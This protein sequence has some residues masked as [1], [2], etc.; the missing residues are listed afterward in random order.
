M[1]IGL[2]GTQSVGKSTLINE[3]TKLPEFKDYYTATE[4]SKHLRDLGIP[5]NTDST[6]LGQFVFIAERARELLNENLLT[7]RSIY[8][9]LAYTLSSKSISMI[10]TEEIVRAAR[11]MIRYYDIIFYVDPTG[12]SIEDNGVRTIDAE[13]R[14]KIDMV[15]KELLDEYP[16]NKLVN[17][18]P[19]LS[20][21]ER[22][23]FIRDIIRD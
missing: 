4:R 21:E 2:T 15:I 9:V 17:I 16:P 22:V 1:K 23:N 11:H 8:D 10:Q 3:L 5:L 12:V 18:P 14:D 13:Y 7:D 20:V 6:L 19:N